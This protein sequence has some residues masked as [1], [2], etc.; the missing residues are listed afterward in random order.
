MLDLT[1]PNRE[2]YPVNLGSHKATAIRAAIRKAGARLLFLPKYSPDLNPIEK[3]FAK[4][5]HWL[6]E[7]QARSREAIYDELQAILNTPSPRKNAQTTS[8]KRDMIEPKNI[9]L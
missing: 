2:G 6:R 1:T 5:K 3:L 9:P 8:S 4:I 7:A